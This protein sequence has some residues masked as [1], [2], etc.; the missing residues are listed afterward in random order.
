MP[1]PRIGEKDFLMYGYIA[2]GVVV[3]VGATLAFIDSKKLR[4]GD[5]ATIPLTAGSPLLPSGTGELRVRVTA[6]DGDTCQGILVD[7]T[8]LGLPSGPPITFKAS[9]VVRFERNGKSRP[10]GK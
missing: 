1:N 7:S 6:R 8:G 2:A 9:N 10:G 4:V 3:A 5:I